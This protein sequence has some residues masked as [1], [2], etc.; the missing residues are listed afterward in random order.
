L[1]KDKPTGINEI[2]NTLKKTTALGKNLEQAEI[3]THWTKLVGKELSEH[4]RPQ[5][6]KDKQLRIE[7][8]SAVWMHRFTYKKWAIIKRINRMA[9][10]KLVDDIF[11]V[12]LGDGESLD[13]EAD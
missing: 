7:V 12:L 4:G 10:K 1:R 5:S 3:W 6:F 9:R 2:L 11:L 8:D 13:E